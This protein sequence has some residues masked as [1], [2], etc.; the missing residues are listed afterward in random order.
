MGLKVILSAERRLLHLRP[1]FLPLRL[2]RRQLVTTESHRLRQVQPQ[3]IQRCLGSFVLLLLLQAVLLQP[4]H[5]AFD[6]SYLHP[7][8]LGRV[9]DVLLALDTRRQ[10]ARNTLDFLSIL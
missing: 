6:L 8:L 7:H 2:Y 9:V 3:D 1:L 5:Q 10:T 4:M